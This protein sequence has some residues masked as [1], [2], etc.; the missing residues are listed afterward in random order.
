MA[1]HTHGTIPSAKQRTK[2]TQDANGLVKT[3]VL[4][5]SWASYASSVPAIGAVDPDNANYFL[6]RS[7]VERQGSEAQITLTYGTLTDTEASGGI[8]ANEYVETSSTIEKPIQQ[9]PDFADWASD[10]DSEKGAFRAGTTKYG[11]ESYLAGTTQVTNT[12]YYSSQ[13]SSDRDDIGTRQAPGG[14]YGS[15]DKWLLIS[16]TR[17]RQGTYYVKE[18]TYLFDT[19]GWNEDL[20]P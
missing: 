4:Y 1:A 5:T 18:N 3:V 15:S 7:E 6:Q 19:D 16:S 17:R 11:I 9:H 13:P 12:S 8:P 10:W 14:S 2:I 20:Y